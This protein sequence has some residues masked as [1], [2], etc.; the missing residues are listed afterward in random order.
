MRSGLGLL[1]NVLLPAAPPPPHL[2]SFPEAWSC[3]KEWHVL[4]PMSKRA[5]QKKK[6]PHVTCH[7]E[8][9]LRLVLSQGPT[10]SS[11]LAR[12]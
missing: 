11:A 2:G 10:S 9:R 1:Y 8:V 3:S 5:P 6:A 12:P 7:Q 4:L